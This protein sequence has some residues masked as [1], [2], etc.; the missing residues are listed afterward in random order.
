MFKN[1]SGTIPEFD[2]G[3]KIVEIVKN[4]KVDPELAFDKTSIDVEK[5]VVWKSTKLGL[6][7]FNRRVIDDGGV[8]MACFLCCKY[9]KKTPT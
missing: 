3:S 4:T 8:I 2:T 6:I 7:F 5:G 9:T 1:N